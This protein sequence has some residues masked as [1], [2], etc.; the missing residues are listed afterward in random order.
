VLSGRARRHS[1]AEA[2]AEQRADEDAAAAALAAVLAELADDVLDEE[3][4]MRGEEERGDG[5]VEEEAREDAE[6]QAAAAAAAAARYGYVMYP[7]AGHRMYLPKQEGAPLTNPQPPPGK[8]PSQAVQ[9]QK[10]NANELPC[11]P[12][13]LRSHQAGRNAIGSGQPSNRED[14]S[15][16]AKNFLRGHLRCGSSAESLKASRLLAHG[17]AG[18]DRGRLESWRASSPA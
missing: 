17:L 14:P 8:E 5:S 11:C 3:E 4:V 16:A 2:E 9:V 15:H 1:R 10:A 6:Y 12:E 7:L 13:G 18:H